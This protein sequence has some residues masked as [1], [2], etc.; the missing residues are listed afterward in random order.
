MKELKKFLQGGELC[1]ARKHQLARKFTYRNGYL[2]TTND[3]PTWEK[4]M[5][6]RAWKER[7]VR[8]TLRTLTNISGKVPCKSTLSCKVYKLCR[9]S[10]KAVGSKEKFRAPALCSASIYCQTKNGILKRLWTL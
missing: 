2:L 7:I 6:G 5:D 4:E 10:Q 9:I 8:L 3:E 1:V